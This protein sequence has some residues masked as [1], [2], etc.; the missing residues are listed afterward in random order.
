L[1]LEAQHHGL[2]LL[3]LLLLGYALEY[4]LEYA[5]KTKQKSKQQKVKREKSEK[6]LPHCALITTKTIRK[7][8]AGQNPVAGH[9]HTPIP[10]YTL[11]LG[12]L[13]QAVTSV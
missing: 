12:P 1:L 9:I 2:L 4:A 7:H 8:L 5:Q 10:L 6:T 13:P 3:L 11:S